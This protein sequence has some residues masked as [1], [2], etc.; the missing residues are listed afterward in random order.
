MSPA[1]GL[2]A[3]LAY[4]AVIIGVAAG[5]TWIVVRFTPMKQ[6]DQPAKR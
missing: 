4:V 6:P 1:I 2:L 5:V 3:F